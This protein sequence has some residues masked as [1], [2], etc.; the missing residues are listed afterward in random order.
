M[1]YFKASKPMLNYDAFLFPVI[2]YIDESSPQETATDSCRDGW[3]VQ[4]GSNV[5]KILHSVARRDDCVLLL[6]LVV[7]LSKHICDLILNKKKHV[8][9]TQRRQLLFES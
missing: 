9:R 6:V 3:N 8:M 1:T 2:D 4:N 5:P 7:L